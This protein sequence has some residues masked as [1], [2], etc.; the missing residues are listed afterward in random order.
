VVV[1]GEL[2]R[3]DPNTSR[4]RGCLL[5]LVGALVVLGLLYVVGGAVLGS[6]Y[7]MYTIP[8]EASSPTLQRGDRIVVD[9]SVDTGRLARGAM[10][11]HRAPATFADPTIATLVKR[12]IGL[13]GESL[14]FERGRV[15]V[16]GAPLDEPWLPPGVPTASMHGGAYE[17]DCSPADPCVVP[18][19][20]Y[21][22]M[23]DNRT[24]SEDSRHHGPIGQDLVVGQVV[25]IWWPLSRAG[26]L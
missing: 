13:P 7:R 8:S 23:G 6:R 1:D 22:V 12:V 3:V 9:L 21:W 26:S 10:I 19:G 25:R 4:R 2:D 14:V 16:D 20:E 18:P 24:D 11:V 15:L 5:R 17:H